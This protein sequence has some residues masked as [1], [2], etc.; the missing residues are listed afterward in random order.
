MIYCPAQSLSIVYKESLNFPSR[1]SSLRTFKQFQFLS[2]ILK[3]R[4]EAT[5]LLKEKGHLA[6]SIL[7]TTVTKAGM[8]YSNF[9]LKQVGSLLDD[10]R[11][12]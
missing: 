8:T 2:P 9:Y 11:D 5:L 1:P 10:Y 4:G 7:V 12:P 3:K 6:I